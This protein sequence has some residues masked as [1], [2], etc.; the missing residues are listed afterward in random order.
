M[1]QLHFEKCAISDNNWKTTVP[2]EY[3]DKIEALRKE[4]ETATGNL[5]SISFHQFG[6]EY[7]GC[8]GSFDHRGCFEVYETIPQLEGLKGRYSRIE[9][10]RSKIAEIKSKNLE[11]TKNRETR[12]VVD[13]ICPFC[14]REKV[15]RESFDTYCHGCMAQFVGAGGIDFVD[16]NMNTGMIYSH[17]GGTLSICTTIGKIRIVS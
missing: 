7:A 12:K 11:A 13:N 15:K 1:A 3:I 6:K 2:Q 8:I 4:M 5:Y 14:Q 9:D 16:I 17:N 10:I